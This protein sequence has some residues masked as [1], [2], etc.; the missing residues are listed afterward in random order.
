MESKNNM[1]KAQQQTEQ[2]AKTEETQEPT[3]TFND[4]AASLQIIDAAIERG[5]FKGKEVT[6]VGGVRDKLER[7][8]SFHQ[9][10]NQQAA[11]EQEKAEEE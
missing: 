11:E 8:I 6:N 10:K 3:V 7:F 9:E 4:V 5:A 1:A 2:A